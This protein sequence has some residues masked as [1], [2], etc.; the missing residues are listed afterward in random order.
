ME[1]NLPLTFDREWDFGGRKPFAGA[2]REK[3]IFNRVSGRW[4]IAAETELKIY[5]TR[6]ENATSDTSH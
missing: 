3:M 6:H 4:Q 5:W 2:E 1:S